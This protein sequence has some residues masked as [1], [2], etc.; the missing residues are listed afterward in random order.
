M[1]VVVIGAGIAGL[2]AATYFARNGHDVTVVEAGDRAGGRNVT[3][4]SKR[5]DKVDA[6]TQYF[7]S[8]YRR[9]LALMDGVGL[10]DRLTKV[11]GPTRFFDPRSPRG[12]YD[13]SHRLPWFPPAGLSN[14]KAVSLIA[15][16]LLNRRDPFALDFPAQADAADAWDRMTDPFLRQFVL[17]QLV[18]AGMLAEPS[19]A[20]PSLAH[21]LRLFRIVVLTDYLVLPGGVASLAQALAAQ[22]RIQYERAATRLAV[23]NDTV[24]G[25]ELASGEIVRAD[26]VVVAVPPPAALT[27]LP[28]AWVTER[29]YL[30]SITIPPFALV[31]FFMDRPVD[32]RVWSYVLPEGGNISLVTDALRKA[33]AMVPSGNSVLQAWAC[34]PASKSLGA[35]SDADIVDA[36]RR[37]LEAFFPHLSDRIEEAHVTRHPYAVPFHPVGHQARTIE[38]LRSADARKGVSF[39][40]DYLSGGFMEAALWSAERAAR[41]SMSSPD[42]T[43]RSMP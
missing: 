40:G 12:H 19:I 42:L 3:L 13:I 1:R 20:R 22:L 17:R 14:F 37:E 23:E 21:I 4:I 41:N 30:D 7:H 35:R 2:G 29:A 25:A 15:R 31:S 36:T 9:A 11:A 6:G 27:L 24:I 43:R 38:F 16:V 34:Y 39:C 18:L 33:P 28:Q 32:A 10:R 5:G 26:H 8:N